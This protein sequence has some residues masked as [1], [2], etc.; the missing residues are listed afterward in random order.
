MSYAGPI[1]RGTRVSDA[2]SSRS[3]TPPTIAVRSRVAARPRRPS[4]DAAPGAVIFA[5]G[6]ALGIA[7][8]AAGALLFA[9]QT[10][11]DTRRAI[12][13]RGRRLGVRGRDAWEDMGDELRRFARRRRRSWQRRRE[14]TDD[15]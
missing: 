7:V 4:A 11:A 15:D 6:V 10:G 1:S 9:P 2:E 14:R 13:R 8:G 12:A 5:A 3:E